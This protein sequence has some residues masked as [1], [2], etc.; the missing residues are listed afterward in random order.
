MAFIGGVGELK[1][2]EIHFE[3]KEPKINS[4]IEHL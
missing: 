1:N 2:S 4:K 3:I